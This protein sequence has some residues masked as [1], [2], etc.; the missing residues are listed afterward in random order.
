MCGMTRRK[1]GILIGGSGLIGGYIMHYF[2]TNASD[3]VDIRAPNSK[4]L[5]I[6]EPEDIGRYLKTVKPDFIINAAVAPIDSDAH[7]AFEINYMGSINLARTAVALDI[8]YVHISSGA[9]MPSGEDLSERDH[10][11]LSPTLSNYAKSK[12]MAELTLAHMHKTEGLDYTMARLGVVYG[13]HD[14]KIQGIQRLLFSI[15]DKTMP[16]MLTK[17]GVM[18]SYSNADKLPC[19]IHYALQH[20]DEFSGQVY[21]FVDPEPVK[22]ADLILTIK[23]H[24]HSRIPREIYIPFP[25]AKVAKSAMGWI[26]KN[27]GRFGVKANMPAEVMFLE[28]FYWTQTLSV[29]KL[30]TTSFPDPD[31]EATIYTK[32]PTLIHYYLTRWEHLN[33]ISNEE[34]FDHQNRAEEFIKSPDILLEKLHKES[35]VPSDF[36]YS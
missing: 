34:I 2:K 4:K 20:R 6:R 3:K 16:F 33:L 28:N 7:M 31:P 9:A 30:K 27:L 5:S 15:V 18:H 36:L 26:I 21:N 1:I 10:L 25:V 29:Q 8:P 13:E 11:P 35:S 12:L 17:K 24:L 14:H 22:M 19:F 23:S 32:L